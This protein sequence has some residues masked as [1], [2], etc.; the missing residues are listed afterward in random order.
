MRT[1][2]LSFFAFREEG[3]SVS[4][5]NVRIVAVVVDL[6]AA[7]SA[8]SGAV[9]LV[10]GYM[11]IPLSTLHG[12]P[13]ADF[14]VPALL[15]GFVVGGSA[16]VAGTIGLFGPR[17]LALF[18]LWRFDAVATA[19]AGCVMVGWMTVEIAMIGLD[20]WVQAAYFVVGLVMM[21][22]AALLQWA[23]WRQTHHYIGAESTRR[24]A[25]A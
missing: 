9:G 7:A 13:F 6:F 4:I 23:E 16:L 5:R 2:A 22:L 10:A 11:K 18:G 14:T 15:L 24:H 8:I 19:V 12:T 20:I 25:A 21:G 1:Q 3:V 17:Q